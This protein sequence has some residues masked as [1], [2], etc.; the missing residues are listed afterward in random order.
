M[1]E[2][3]YA[4]APDSPRSVTFPCKSP[5]VSRHERIT[6]LPAIGRLHYCLKRFSIQFGLISR[7]DQDVASAHGLLLALGWL[8]EQAQAHAHA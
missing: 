4:Q 5:P 3:V 6:L 2:V 8:D 1:A 7:V